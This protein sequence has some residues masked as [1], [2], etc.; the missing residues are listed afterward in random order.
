MLRAPT[1][2]T[3]ALAGSL[4]GCASAEKL[5]PSPPVAAE[6]L[7]L[8]EGSNYIKL[9]M[10][11]G[12]A[13]GRPMPTLGP[14]VLRAVIAAAHVRG[15]LALVY[16]SSQ[17]EAITAIEAGADGLAHVF[18]DSASTPAFVQLAKQRGVL[19]IPS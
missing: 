13:L 12:G 7:D 8:A 14:E 17:R 4:L 19:S 1:V 6:K 9:V 10:D 2:F 16:V 5:P 3:L 11:D 15:K 18:F